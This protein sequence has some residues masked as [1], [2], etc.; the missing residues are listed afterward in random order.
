MATSTYMADS[1]PCMFGCERHREILEVPAMKD[2]GRGILS[3]GC[4]AVIAI[5]PRFLSPVLQR[6]GLP[7]FLNAIRSATSAT[8]SA[9]LESGVKLRWAIIRWTC[10]WYKGKGREGEGPEGEGYFLRLYR[11]LC[12]RPFSNIGLENSS[13]LVSAISRGRGMGR[14]GKGRREKGKGYAV[15]RH[16]L[17]G[18]APN[19]I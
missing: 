13:I 11:V 7:R 1:F 4:L 18:N 15:K 12:N 8:P 19:S 9:I 10:F 6:S 2:H 14:K 3:D 16:A 5:A 17:V